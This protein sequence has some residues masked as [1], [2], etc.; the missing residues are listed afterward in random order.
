VPL[1]HRPAWYFRRFYAD[2]ALFG[3]A[4][5]MRCGLAYFPPDRV[6]FGSDMPFDPEGGPRYIRDTIRDLDDSGIAAEHRRM[7][8][9]DNFRR[10]AAER[11]RA[12][13]PS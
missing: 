4:H 9:E 8:D 1:A 2:T 5:A 13:T 3:A 11:T 10:L 12:R 6:L 7:I